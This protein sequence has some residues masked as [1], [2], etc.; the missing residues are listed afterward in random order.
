MQL[1]AFLLVLVTYD[2]TRKIFKWLGKNLRRDCLG[3]TDIMDIPS[4]KAVLEENA[5]LGD[6]LLP[7]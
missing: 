7:C 4:R 2:I 5:L 1:F 6:L 3:G